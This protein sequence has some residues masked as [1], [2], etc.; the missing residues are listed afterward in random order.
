[1]PESVVDEL[2]EKADMFKNYAKKHYFLFSKSGFTPACKKRANES[3]KLIEF[4]N[5]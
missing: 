3:I 5:M 4:K 2:I 1:M